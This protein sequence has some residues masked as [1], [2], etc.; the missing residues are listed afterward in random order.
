MCPSTAGQ[1]LDMEAR[2][3]SS[4]EHSW[5]AG[6]LACLEV[7]CLAAATKTGSSSYVWRLVCDVLAGPET[8]WAA[9][10]QPCCGADAN[11]SRTRVTSSRI[12]TGGVLARYPY[13]IL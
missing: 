1:S 9:G 6:G 2:C 12:I 3:G 7:D 8:I 13:M 11:S 10:V 5:T 4:T